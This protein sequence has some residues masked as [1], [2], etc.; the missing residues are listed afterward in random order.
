MDEVVLVS[1]NSIQALNLYSAHTGQLLKAYKPAV[2]FAGSSCR[3]STR[4]SGNPRFAVGPG[5]TFNNFVNNP[6]ND[7]A[8]V[9]GPALDSAAGAVSS[10]SA[11]DSS[12]SG[13]SVSGSMPN[14][15]PENFLLG[16]QKDKP[17]MHVWRWNRDQ[18]YFKFNLVEKLSA[19]VCTP[20][21]TYTIGGSVSGY[22]YVWRNGTGELLEKFKGH[23]KAV[24]VLRVSEE[25]LYVVSGGEDAVVHVWSLMDVLD[26][27]AEKRVGENSR[28]I[29]AVYSWADHALPVTDICVGAG[30]GKKGRVYTASLDRTCRVYDLC[31]G[32]M[33]RHEVLE[34]SI[35]AI[36]VDRTEGKLWA[37]LAD[38]SIV[39]VPLYAASLELARV[40][41]MMMA[42]N[43]NE[44]GEPKRM[45]TDEMMKIK[46]N[47]TH[48]L[49]PK[50]HSM[51]VTCM[52]LNTMGNVLVSGDKEG[53][54]LVWDA[55]SG[56]V[57]KTLTGSFKTHTENT[58]SNDAT[59]TTNSSTSSDGNKKEIISIEIFPV[60]LGL[61]SQSNNTNTAQ[62]TVSNFNVSSSI[63]VVQPFKKQKGKVGFDIGKEKLSN[64]ECIPM[65]LGAN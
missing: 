29:R 24:T 32:K 28:S 11:G 56:Q 61:Y 33:M 47:G 43:D 17:V 16:A 40:N 37:G 4:A 2:Q 31:S 21:G 26:A 65:V 51:S 30:I 5:A 27:H 12:S 44:N 52:S 35:H 8:Y 41:M 7:L 22:I 36:V 45:N 50:M 46:N 49:L 19:L 3:L 39:L 10:T 15:G 57:L 62:S 9:N 54:A 59:S 13:P 1:S 58:M 20:D 55:L 42:A 64:L 34:H 63:G 14:N 38:G 18:V 25:G 60:P 23:Y 53:K 6:Y 48:I